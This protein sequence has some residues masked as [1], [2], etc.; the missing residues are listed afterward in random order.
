MTI[1]EKAFALCD[2]FGILD[3]K[4]RSR[5]VMGYQH[6][7][8]DARIE[9]IEDAMKSVGKGRPFTDAETR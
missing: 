1:K 2:Q 8:L 3:D 9:A 7:H 5:F 6:G 4:E